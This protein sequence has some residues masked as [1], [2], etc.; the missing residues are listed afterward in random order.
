MLIMWNEMDN[1]RKSKTVTSIEM[2]PEVNG[3][4]DVIYKYKIIDK[5][6]QRIDYLRSTGFFSDRACV[7]ELENIRIYIK[8]MKT[9]VI[10]CKHCKHC[11]TTDNYTY[12]H[13]WLRETSIDGYCYKGN[14]ND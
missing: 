2:K 12:C 8:N 11:E 1:D 9:D 5:I 10:N 4:S 13:E 14:A 6:E 3:M 7:V